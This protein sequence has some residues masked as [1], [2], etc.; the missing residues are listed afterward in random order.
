MIFIFFYELNLY[1]MQFKKY[2]NDFY[3]KVKISR[4]IRLLYKMNVRFVSFVIPT[5]EEAGNIGRLIKLINE[6]TK[7]HNINN[8]ILVIDD[9]SED[10]TI[11]EVEELQKNQSNL[12]LIQRAYYQHLFP[13]YPKKWK[14]IGLGSAHKIGYNLSQGDLIISMDGDL[15]ND[16]KEIPKLLEKIS[17]GYDICVGSRYIGGG[18]SDK[19]LINQVIS[20]FG[21]SYITMLSG[22]K[23]SDFST[24]YRAIKKDIWN[25][26]KDIQY[27]NDN[28]FLIESV[29]FAYKAGAKI[30]EIP[31]FFKERE[32]GESKTPLIKETIKALILP[33]KLKSLYRKKSR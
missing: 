28:N 10:G 14:Y 26:I 5:K 11:Q 16:P 6:T 2:S 8:E 7:K 22:I 27:T 12:K 13:K 15:S 30:S 18:G 23:I 31:I 33:F 17:E 29:Y 9:Q 25:K 32:I 21:N 20:R 3:K 1:K 19:N 24:G 4:K